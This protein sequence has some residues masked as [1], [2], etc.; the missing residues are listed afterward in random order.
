MC[1]TYIA[2]SKGGADGCCYVLG[3]DEVTMKAGNVS[4]ISRLR[5]E[6]LQSR[7]VVELLADKWRIPILHVLGKRV[8]RTHELQRAIRQVSPKMLTQTLRGMERD[9]LVQRTMQ[10]IAPPHVEYKL[11][12]MG[13]SVIPPLRVL[14]RWAETHVPERNAARERFDGDGKGVR[15][16][17]LPGRPSGQH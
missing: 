6:A 5:A 4:A 11:T 14:C 2:S 10:P 3:G 15:R 1:A 17:A 7:E 9:G 8:L 13:R 12:R 16:S